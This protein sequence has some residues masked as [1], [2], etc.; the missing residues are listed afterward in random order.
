MQT[1]N[2]NTKGVNAVIGWYWPACYARKENG[3]PRVGK[4]KFCRITYSAWR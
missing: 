2:Q 4:E 1:L 3:V